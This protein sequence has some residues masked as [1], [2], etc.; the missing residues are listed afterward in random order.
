[1]IDRKKSIPRIPRPRI[2]RRRHQRPNLDLAVREEG[3]QVVSRA[4][5]NAHRIEAEPFNVITIVEANRLRG[6]NTRR[7]DSIE[8]E[9]EERPTP[10][11]FYEDRKKRRRESGR[12]RG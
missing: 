1:M 4:K 3:T 2:P 8:T 9:L 6:V 5:M 7:N 11:M 12:G 10:W